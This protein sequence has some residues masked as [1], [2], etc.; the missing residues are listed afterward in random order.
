MSDSTQKKRT[1]LIK[2][3][4]RIQTESGCIVDLDALISQF[5][6]AA[7]N[8]EASQWIFDPPDGRRKTPEEIVDFALTKK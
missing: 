4:E 7:P 1:S 3:V 2:L 8:A 6:K 5:E